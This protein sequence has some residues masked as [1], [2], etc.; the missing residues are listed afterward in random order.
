VAIIHCPVYSTCHEHSGWPGRSHAV[1]LTYQSK[2]VCRG[3]GD[4]KGQGA[5][6]YLSAAQRRG[7]VGGQRGQLHPLNFGLSKKFSSCGK[8]FV[9]LVLKKIFGELTSKIKIFSIYN[10]LWRKITPFCP[11]CCLT[12]DDAT[13]R[14]YRSSQC[15]AP[16]SAY[17]SVVP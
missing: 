12:H 14:L 7:R 13:W 9:H 1:S 15:F 4:P 16:L 11:A 17:T 3:A 5:T 2:L 8:I 10:H 6:S